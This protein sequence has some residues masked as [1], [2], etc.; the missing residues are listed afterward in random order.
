MGATQNRNESFNSLIWARAPK[1]EF[2]GKATVDLAVSQ[3]V[4]TFNSGCQQALLPVL[5]GVGAQPGSNCRTFLAG[6]DASRVR[7]AE[8]KE[9]AVAKLRKSKRAVDVRVE[10]A[11]V[12]EEGVTYESGSF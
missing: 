3:A 7:Q 6:K 12:Q 5:E 11:R 10:E 2:V 1:T 8:G 9:S 4:V